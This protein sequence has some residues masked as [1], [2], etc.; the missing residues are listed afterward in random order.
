MLLGELSYLQQAID[1]QAQSV[2]LA[3]INHP[4]RSIYLNDLGLSLQI[5]FERLGER[6]D[7][8]RA[9][10]YQSQ[11][12][13]L[14]PDGDPF[15]P[16]YLSSLGVSLLSRFKQ[17]GELRDLDNG[18]QRHL[19]SI[20][21]TPD[22]H[23]RRLDRLTNLGA[24]WLSRFMRLGEL[25]DLERARKCLSESVDLTPDSHPA[26]L[27]F[28]LKNLGA[29]LGARFQR[30]E[31]LPDL[32]H[33]IACHSQSANLT[34]D[35]DPD[36][37]F[38]LNNLGT[39]LNIRFQRLGELPDLDQAIECLSRSVHLTPDGHPYKPT[40]LINLGNSWKKRFDQTG[41]LADLEHAIEHQSRS[42]HLTPDGHPEKPGRLHNLGTLRMSRFQHLQR[43]VD[44][45]EACDAFMNGAKSTVFRP[46]VQMRCARSWAEATL[47]VGR[48]P[49]EAYQVAFSLLPRLVWIGQKID[50]RYETMTTVRDLATEAAAWAIS[51]RLYDLALEWLEQ[52]RSVVWGQKLQLRT[53]FEQLKLVDRQLAKD[54]KRVAS[55]LDKAG[56]GPVQRLQGTLSSTDLMP[57]A[58]RH[59]E[60]AL[61][62]DRLLG[63]AR[64]LKGFENFLR[65]L[66]SN[67]LKQAAK[68]GPVVVINTHHA[69]CDA[70]IILPRS[71]D[72]THVSLSGVC[73]EKLNR[74]KTDVHFIMEER[75]S[76]NDA[77]GFTRHKTE[78]N[79][80]LPAVIWSDIVGPI[81]KTLKCMGNSKS[82]ELPHVTWCTTGAMSFI[83]LHA[84]G[85]YDGQS[86]NALDLIVSSYTPTLTALLLHTKPSFNQAGLVAIGQ[87]ASPGQT[88]LPNTVIE[89]EIIN[90][91]YSAGSCCQLE[92]AS[93][94]VSAT[95][96]AMQE[97]SWVH[98]ACHAVQNR[99]NASQSAFHLYDG[100]LTLEEISRQ[101]FK[102]KG[103]A[104]LSACQTATGDH[105]LPDEATHL[106][107]GMLM[108]GYP[109]VIG[110]MW[111]IR[112]EDAPLVADTV[113]S[114]MLEDGKMDHTRS[115][116]ALHK[117][118][119]VLQE[120]ADENEIWRWAPFIH[121]GV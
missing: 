108:A 4:E 119:K 54:L 23:P 47:L 121:I 110:T 27:A 6:A 97:N 18:V 1:L 21:L 55:K 29:S 42:V 30:F 72:I 99:T 13:H 48:S 35:G 32:D 118:V 77:R 38:R 73:E 62:W 113:Y 78:R 19:Q 22:D 116:R 39:S 20:E 16:A 5:R 64:L 84:A 71:D 52:G 76:L 95:L 43:L 100:E 10:E 37:P 80:K 92:G 26:K 101:Q 25:P 59:H 12:V 86:P 111:S 74:L 117:A 49:I 79:I 103:L 69:Q 115:A 44:L 45:E 14:A 102:D 87:A 112:D 40:C 11:S 53:P 75:G 7:I 31:E 51:H 89:L 66:K 50:H 56:S 88:T 85:L 9:I 93:A 34:P 28:R 15:M 65:P 114:T 94:T 91:Y 8:D 82:H 67:E 105:G 107:A 24:A 36:K 70:L 120:R 61:E 68:D 98:L 46:D 109:S 57:Q 58:T 83:P 63:Q 17:T 104:F 90:K 106:A 2:H 60:L 33:A 41:E 96:E 81:L 3:P